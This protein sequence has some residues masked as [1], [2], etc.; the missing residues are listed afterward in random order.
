MTND[1][2]CALLLVEDDAELLDKNRRRFSRR[3]YTVTAVSRSS[4]AET[5]ARQQHFHVAVLDRKLSGGDGL[6][7]MQS[8]LRLHSDLHVILLSGQGDDELKR[9]ALRLGAY[10]C[11]TQPCRV[12]ELE[13]TTWRAFKECEGVDR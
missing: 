11:L 7:L 10:A 9:A 5:V 2:N 6:E 13:A 4:E 12:D 1:F 8:L 3:G